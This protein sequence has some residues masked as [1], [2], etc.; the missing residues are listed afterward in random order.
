MIG[1]NKTHLDREL[2]RLSQTI[3]GYAAFVGMECPDAVRQ[4]S[5]LL[6]IDLAQHQAPQNPEALG[7]RMDRDAGR[8]FYGFDGDPLPS[9]P[10]LVWTAAG[11][12]FLLGTPRQN[13]EPQLEPSE[14]RPLFL[15]AGGSKG[16]K[17]TSLGSRGK[18]HVYQVNRIFVSQASLEQFRAGT[19]KLMGKLKASFAAA[20]TY[21]RA[22][23]QLDEHTME[24]IR[25]GDAHGSFVDGTGNKER[26]TFTITSNSPGCSKP[27]SLELIRRGLRIRME[28]MVTRARY[29]ARKQKD[30][31]A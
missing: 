23:T 2:A 1:V 10:D 29:I 28:K 21:L 30:P 17:M 8:V 18:Q 15:Q 26:P 3:G 20:W 19:R 9:G 13:F 12:R 27:R 11:P 25:A 14:M 7:Q 4:Q 5:R 24:H 31:E 22:R 16:K 6:M